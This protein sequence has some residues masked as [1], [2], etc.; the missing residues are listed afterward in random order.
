L[1]SGCKPPIFAM[2]DTTSESSSSA[3]G[4]S[5]T[6]TSLGGDE[7]QP[8]TQD[9]P[10]ASSCPSCEKATING[11]DTVSAFLNNFSRAFSQ[12]HPQKSSVRASS[13]R[14]SQY[15]QHSYC[16]EPLA[17]QNYTRLLKLEPGNGDDPIRCNIQ[18]MDIDHPP[19]YTALSY[20]W[21]RADEKLAI[22]VD[23]HDFLI[24]NNLWN[25]LWHIRSRDD[26]V[27]IWVDAICINQVHNPIHKPQEYDTDGYRIIST[28]ETTLSDA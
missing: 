14:Q 6:A 19:K 20:T 25:A 1:Y 7:N 3:V 24:R 17:D 4:N 18:E 23:R 8:S 15:Q 28:S 27:A 26:A 16:Y 5:I 21:G 10:S 22:N 11:N 9:S 13:S 12:N 2:S